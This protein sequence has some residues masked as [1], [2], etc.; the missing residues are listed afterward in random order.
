VPGLSSPVPR[1]HVAPAIP[2]TH[3]KACRRLPRLR[4]IRLQAQ[5]E[6]H[7]ASL[8][9]G[10]CPKDFTSLGSLLYSSSLDTVDRLAHLSTYVDLLSIENILVP[11]AV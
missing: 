2:P 6:Q 1:S 8:E 9:D 7:P 3:P 4:R 11:N 5:H 10:I